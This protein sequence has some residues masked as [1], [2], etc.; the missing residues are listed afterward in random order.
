MSEIWDNNSSIEEK[1]STVLTPQINQLK[2]YFS[3]GQINDIMNK[4]R[5]NKELNEADYETLCFF[6]DSKYGEHFSEYVDYIKKLLGDKLKNE[7]FKIKLNNNKEKIRKYDYSVIAKYF[8]NNELDLENKNLF[9]DI[10]YRL[11]VNIPELFNSDMLSKEYKAKIEVILP[12]NEIIKRDQEKSKLSS[13]STNIKYTDTLYQKKLSNNDFKN[14][15]IK[16]IPPNYTNL[17]KSIYI[18]IKLC[19]L[20]SYDPKY[21][22]NRAKYKFEHEDFDNISKIGMEKNNVICYEFVTIYMEMLKDLGIN[23]VTTTEFDLTTDEE[24]NIEISNFA[25]KHSYLKYSIDG[26]TIFADSTTSVLSGDIIN[27]KLNNPL[28]GLRCLS[29]E[30]NKKSEFNNALSKVYDGLKM[31]NTI[32]KKYGKD[33]KDKSLVEKLKILFDDISN[34][35]FNSTDFI[36]YISS[37]KHELFNEIELDWNLKISFIGKNKNGEQYP[38]AIFSVNTNDIKNIP[39]DTIQYMYDPIDKKVSKIE[40]EELERMFRDGDL[41]FI[42]RILNIPNIDL[43]NNKSL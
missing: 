36:S 1:H 25:D 6:I 39:N 11:M 21:F 40:K 17:E 27:A 12:E 26:M 5:N 4:Y 7:Y 28:I 43:S 35:S 18:Y 14:E 13:D 30:E 10:L 3:I 31:D 8:F 19:Q 33:V 23:V 16:N 38:V 15:I 34:T 2:V 37:I 32:F 41:F 42:D 22:V 9:K 29:V 20:L 24:D